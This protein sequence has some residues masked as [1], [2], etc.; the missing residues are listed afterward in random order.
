[1]SSA[2][3]GLI[4][5]IGG[6]GL[7]DA[8]CQPG[9]GKMV[10]IT[11]PYGPPSG[12]ILLTEWQGQPLAILARHGPGHRFNPTNVPYRANIFALKKIGVTHLIA[13]GA[14]GS[15]REEIHPGDLVIP[16]QLID[17]TFRRIN[18][19]FEQDVVVHVEFSQPFCPSLRQALLAAGNSL[20]TR[21]HAGGVYVC[22]EGP[23]FST[24]AEAN[25]H[26][27]W[28]GDLIGMTALPEAK[29]AREAEMCYTLVAFPTDYDC[30]K[31]HQSGVAPQT[32]L[33]EILQNVQS[34]TQLAIQLIKN[35]VAQLAGH[36][37]TACSCQQALKL[38][39]WSDR[40]QL[41][42][43]KLKPLEP[44]LNRY[45]EFPNE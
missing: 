5:I 42:K 3:Q 23:A 14:T 33:Q 39:I 21:V 12:P 35:T 13:S 10:E 28:G 20:P 6:T 44:L 27:Q 37:P 2:V 11:T 4:G 40:R 1:M 18:T 16:S 7:G 36:L 8:L 17:N 19:F 25:R 15:L 30:W 45:L 43:R 31:P 41:D 34:A 38:A 32:L 22:M 24:V 9:Q 29:L 26:R